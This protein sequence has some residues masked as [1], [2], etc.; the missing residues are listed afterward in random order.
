MFSGR[1]DCSVTRERSGRYRTTFGSCIMANGTVRP[2]QGTGYC[3][4]NR[5]D[6]TPQILAYVS[7]DFE[8]WEY[9]GETWQH[10]E[11]TWNGNLELINTDPLCFQNGANPGFD[12]CLDIGFDLCLDIGS[13]HFGCWGSRPKHVSNPDSVI[14][15]CVP[16]LVYRPLLRGSADTNETH[17]T[18]STVDVHVPRVECPYQFTASGQSIT[19]CPYHHAPM[20]LSPPVSSQS[21]YTIIYITAN[22]S[23][24]NQKGPASGFEMCFGWDPST[25]PQTH[26]FW[27]GPP[28]RF[29]PAPLVPGALTKTHLESGIQIIA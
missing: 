17:V 29:P 23:I 26:V 19:V 10:S 11:W 1:W 14:K 22:H 2:H 16:H 3:D 9:L 21:Q 13:R 5:Q 27:L 8:T 4:G 6:G 12:L 7:D 28:A 25:K 20:T 24:I 18:V 15:K